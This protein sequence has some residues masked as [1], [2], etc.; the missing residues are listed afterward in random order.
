MAEPLLSG[1]ALEVVNRFA[2]LSHGEQGA[3]LDAC[4]QRRALHDRSVAVDICPWP[5]RWQSEDIA[6][7][8]AGSSTAAL[9]SAQHLSELPNAVGLD[10]PYL[11]KGSPPVVTGCPWCRRPVM[12]KLAD[13]MAA[14][15]AKDCPQ[16][17]GGPVY[18]TLIYGP[19]CHEYFLGA[20]VLG[21]CLAQFGGSVERVLMH[22]CDVP[23]SYLALLREYWT[24]LIEVKYVEKVSWTLFKRAGGGR[25][26]NIFTKLSALSLT[27][28]SK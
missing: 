20:L 10:D 14:S 7:L 27:Q 24:T 9:C 15:S 2:A 22:T 6:T 16:S 11:E 3:V 25:F 5:V 17:M 21:R 26:Y 28:Y 1:A 4:L 8:H 13:S 18:T 19:A 12:L 23:A